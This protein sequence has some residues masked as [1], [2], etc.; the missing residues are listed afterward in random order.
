MT[1]PVLWDLEWSDWLMFAI[2]AD[3]WLEQQKKR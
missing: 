3:D 2:G 1:P